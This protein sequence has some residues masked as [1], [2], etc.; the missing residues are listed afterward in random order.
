MTPESIKIL[1]CDYT[2][3]EEERISRDSYVYGEV[4]HVNQ[5][6]KLSKEL[7][8]QL[9]AET[10]LHEIIHAVLFKLREEELFNNEHFVNSM[11]VMLL[12]VFRDNPDL[13]P[14]FLG[15]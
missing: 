10:L 12:Q 13:F 4:D 5:V 15:L 6:I 2:V 3:I 7:K 9:K 14:F 1:G 8:R 11:S